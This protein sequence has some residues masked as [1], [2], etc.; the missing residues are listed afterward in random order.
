M[1]EVI[2]ALDQGT[3]GSTALVFAADGSIV[4]RAYVE[5][6]QHYPQ[7]GWVE[8]DPEELWQLSRRVMTDALADAGTTPE[9][10]RGLGITNQR[11]TTIL[12]DKR[13]GQ[14]VHRAIVWQSRQSAAVC[15]RLRNEGLEARIRQLTGLVIDPYF[16]ASKI[17]W[18]FD[19]Y[20]EL[21][22]RA[23]AGEV[24]F[25]TVDSWLVWR[26]TAGA[27]HVTDPTNA[28]RTLLY[29]IHDRRWDPE[30][31]ELLDIPSAI[32][33]SVK[34]SSGFFGETVAHDGLR[35]G[36]PITG[37]AGDQQSALYGQA[38]WDP[39][40]AKNTYGTGAF[41]VMQLGQDHPVL[42][43]GLLT[44]VCC[45]ARGQPAYALE[46]SIF[47][48]GA[49]IQWLRDELQIIER[50]G[51]TE[52]LARSIPD[53][54]GVYLVPAFTGLGV[55]YWDMHARGA[56]VG[57]TRGTNRRHL[58]RAALESLA[59]QTRDVVDAMRRSGV[60]LKILRV[61][62]GAAANDF[63]MQFQADILG[64]DV[65]RPVVLETTAAGAAFL[66][67]LGA[68]FWKT[69]D[70]L[71]H[72][73]RREQLFTPDMARPERNAL[74]AGWQDAVRRILSSP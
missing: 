30:L 27:V 1:D 68:G 43:H 8:Q 57:L 15:E 18:L 50:A 16:S 74:Y 29:N 6:T 5:L 70:A 38:C 45:D 48:A 44:T 71:R 55:P 64:V 42:E 73:R 11:E 17:I 21:R 13:T 31:L 22:A 23:A 36:I 28:S 52:S 63:L 49:A 56:I 60:D 37:I 41:V 25:G 69:P 10:V 14:P 58:V 7:P 12:W 67:G 32:L 4:G 3:T 39:G 51:D 61:D 19:Q 47:T 26:L 66:A 33:P 62:G 54:G 72:L 53:T 35:A 34:P 46:G 2:L 24:V 40:Q 9:S 65:D 59:Y 20:P